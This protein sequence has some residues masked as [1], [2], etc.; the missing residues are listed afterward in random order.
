[1]PERPRAPTVNAPTWTTVDSHVPE[2]G[3]AAMCRPGKIMKSGSSAAGTDSG[4]AAATTY[5]LDAN[6]SSPS[7]RQTA[8]MA[9][10]R[11]FHNL[12]L[13]PDG[14]AVAVGGEMR[15]DGSDPS[16]AVLATEQWSPVTESWT[17]GA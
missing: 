14:N 6:A 16:Q 11:A 8:P 1:P 4:P 13:L 3:R 7:W 12:V 5:V 10:P 15:R 17:T 2:A 9:Y